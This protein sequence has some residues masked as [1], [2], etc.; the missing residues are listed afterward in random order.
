MRRHQG[1]RGRK[2]L[3]VATVVLIVSAVAYAVHQSNFFELGPGTG[4]GGSTNILGDGNA[5]NGPDWADIFAANGSVN[6]LFG[7]TAASFV[8]DDVSS[9]E[10]N[11]RTA[12]PKAGSDKNSDAVADWN[13]QSASVPSKDDITNAYVYARINPANG[14]LI[15]YSGVE[16]ED[17][18]GA[19]HIDI[20]FFQQAVGLSEPPACDAPPCTFTG[21]N[22]DNDLLVNLDFTQGG[23]FAGLS[24]RK[25]QEG[26][27]D[28]YVLLSTL[29][30]EGCNAGTGTDPYDP[31]SI[32]AFA[33]HGT[34][35]G[36]PWDNFDN[37]GA[38][39]TNLPPNAFSEFGVDVTEVLGFTPCFSTVQVK[40]R[41]SQSFTAELK[42]FA[43]ASFQQ[44]SATAAT[45]IH[46]GTRGGA[47][48]TAADIQGTT[49]AAGTTI[50]D[51]VLVTGTIGFATPTGNV[52][53][54]RYANSTCSGTPAATET[55]AL[56]QIA[57]P[58]TTTAGVA[59]AESSDFLT[60]AGSL[61]YKAV[62]AGD[63]NYSGSVA[64]A[65]EPLT[66]SKTSSAVNTDIRAGGIGGAS[67]LNTKIANGTSVV[68]VAIITGSAPGNPDPT[69]TVTF[70]RYTTANCSGTAISPA[71][72][73]TLTA[74]SNPT[75]GTAT[76][77]ATA[78]TTVSAAGEFVS[79]KV[80]YSGDSNYQPS[81]S[82]LCEPL[83][84]F[85]SSPAISTPDAG[86]P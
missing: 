73:V 82:T 60:A 30:G 25:R 12:F 70:E 27:K 65:C 63:S 59:A 49:V 39:I 81:A 17:P 62:Y 20:E 43:L 37:H 18:S 36:G 11:D 1:N 56:T 75:D 29:D 80:S 38:I 85:N 14:H 84:S 22:T 50:H 2:L 7:G 69:G 47:S 41:S 35:D 32:C 34:I 57:A 61:S 9:G 45:Q 19:S 28:N 76:A 10:F 24:I 74:D 53:F 23:S 21:D 71:E 67:V 48:H 46:S 42:D 52:T 44:C 77:V 72:I 5:A 16:R 4:E 55:V 79:Y 6:G 68:D 78:Y 40:T 3:A 31:D 54:S 64:A 51:K 83:C 58:T 86:V 66:V 33:N 15:I 26:G 13:W 8:K